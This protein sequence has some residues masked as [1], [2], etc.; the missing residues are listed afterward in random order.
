MLT[1][2]KAWVEHFKLEKGHQLTLSLVGR[3]VYL[4]L[5]KTEDAPSKSTK[6]HIDEALQGEAL[7][8]TLISRYIAGF[9]VLEISGAITAEQREDIRQTVQRLIGAEIL[10]ET[11]EFTLIHILRDPHVLSVNQLLDY[12]SENVAGM[13]RDIPGCLR[14]DQGERA[15]SVIQRDERVDRFFLLM[16]RRLYAA[17]R[18]PLAEVAHKI[19]RVNFF[20]THNV[21]RQLERVADHAV[22][23]AQVAQALLEEHI[24]VPQEMQ[25]LVQ[26]T[27]QEAEAF[28][29]QV[30]KAFLDFD[31]AAAHQALATKP[32]LEKHITQLDKQV[33]DLNNSYLAYHLGIAVDSIGR[34]K[35]Y[36]ANIAEVAL[37]AAA[38]QDQ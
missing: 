15:L 25:D 34:V 4:N 1:L 16:S 10:Q 12:I 24:K 7:V 23:I 17:L 35:D 32:K 36:A 29:R 27:S 38:L 5:D 18:N 31:A 11:G 9:N 8:R 30:M 13:L 19:S 2:P 6:L 14:A 26:K 28:L 33:L 20:N 22:K 3:G 37:N 21:A